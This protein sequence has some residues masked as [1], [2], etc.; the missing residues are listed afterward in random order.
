MTGN[1]QVLVQVRVLAEERDLLDSFAKATGLSR[2]QVMRSLIHLL[3]E[4]AE[5]VAEVV[6][7]LPER[8][9][10]VAKRERTRAASR[11]W[12][13]RAQRED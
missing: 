2:V 13:Q 1:E 3:P 10:D 12:V 6:P 7:G 9:A 4:M 11:A 5:R 8:P